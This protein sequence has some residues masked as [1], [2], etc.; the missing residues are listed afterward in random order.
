MKNQSRA[1]F[2]LIE[3]MVA[4]ALT[5][6]IMVILSQAFVQSLEAF[7]QLKAIGDM[8]SNLRTAENLIRDDLSHAHFEGSRRLSDV[9]AA[10]QSRIVLEPPQEGFIAVRQSSALSATVTAPYVYEGDDNYGISSYRATDHYLYMTVRR[11]GNRQENFFTTAL[12]GQPAVLG[13]FFTPQ[14]A[15]NLNPGVELPVA[16]QTFPYVAGSSTGFYSSQWAEVAY[17][18]RRTGS[19]EEP[20]NPASTIGTPTFSLYRAQLVMAPDRTG[21]NSVFTTP[22][23]SGANL[24][25]L[26]Q[27]TFGGMS[28]QPTPGAAAPTALSFFSPADAALGQRVIPNLASFDP[29]T[30]AR[31]YASETLL[32]PNVVSFQVQIMPVGTNVNFMDVP[33]FVYDTALPAYRTGGLKALQITIRIFD[34]KTRQSRQV[35]IVQD[36]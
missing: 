34:L 20:A 17:Y 11:K 8:Q 33:G 19:T 18:L 15:Y 9:N 32:L 16:T 10:G 26:S 25:A 13:A 3:L 7:S 35:S 23:Y 1:G 28:C 27:T 14:T 12:N 30:D 31:V 21:L 22:A 29:N 6:F 36:L 2:T 24:V 4:M 5:L